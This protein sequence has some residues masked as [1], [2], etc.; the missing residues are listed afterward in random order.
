MAQIMK[1]A[2]TT[3]L[4]F[5]IALAGTITLGASPAAAAF[6]CNAN[7]QHKEF[8]TP[9]TDTDFYI[10]LCVQR[11]SDSNRYVAYALGTWTDGGGVVDK[12]EKFDIHL[13]LEKSN[14][15]Q[16]SSYCDMGPAIY[17][18][19]TANFDRYGDEN[20]FALDCDLEA[21][22]TSTSRNNWT[23]DGYIEYNINNDGKGT[24][25]WSLGGTA[26][27]A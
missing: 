15:S 18:D 25:T 6:Q 8:P 17:L 16:A 22:K 9:G 5:G 21:T 24:Q 14:V 1:R 26:S 3:A 2:A 10:R 19:S 12:F 23:A 4:A 11:D 27:I 7:R 13:R 20:G